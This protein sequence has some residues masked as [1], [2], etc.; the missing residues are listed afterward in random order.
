MSELVVADSAK[1]DL[2][3][4]ATHIGQDNPQ[5][6]KTLVEE[7]IAK[8]R[9]VAERPLSFPARDKWKTG[10]RAARHRRYFILFRLSGDRI[11]VVRVLHAARDIAR[12]L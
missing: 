2:R 6:A 1:A 11:E 3:D 5:R 12:L 8:M 10:Y 4:I 9:V 7:L